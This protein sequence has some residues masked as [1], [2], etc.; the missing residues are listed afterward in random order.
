MKFQIHIYRWSK[1]LLDTYM[2]DIAMAKR[3]NPSLFLNKVGVLL[4]NIRSK[5]YNSGRL[6]IYPTLSVV[7][8]HN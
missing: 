1:E 3:V 8:D 4:E 6:Q 5:A 7:E 2:V